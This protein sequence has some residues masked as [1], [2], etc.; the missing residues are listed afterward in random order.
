MY[1]LEFKSTVLRHEAAGLAIAATICSHL[2]SLKNLSPICDLCCWG[3][4]IRA[5]LAVYMA[6]LSINLLWW[7][8][9]LRRC[10]WSTQS[11]TNAMGSS[12]LVFFFWMWEGKKPD[13]E[14][15]LK[16]I[17]WND[18]GR[19]YAQGTSRYTSIFSRVFTENQ[20]FSFSHC[21]L[22]SM[23][24]GQGKFNSFR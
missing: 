9:G 2:W 5:S 21:D 24:A 6:W 10:R 11:G 15:R 4:K 8:V 18:K 14:G 23:D 20:D 17:H 1:I 7:W 13:G 19:Y 3:Q 12:S 22:S 16:K